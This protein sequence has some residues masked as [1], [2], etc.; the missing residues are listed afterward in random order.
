[1]RLA[2]NGFGRLG[3]SALH[4]ALKCE[5]FS[6]AFINDVASLSGGAYLFES[7]SFCGP[8]PGRGE[9]E[10]QSLIV[11]GQAIP[12][13][14]TFD[15]RTI[16]LS[17]VD[18][19]LECTGQ[20]NPIPLSRSA[21]AAGA[22]RVV[23]SGPSVGADVM[24]VIGANENACRG[25]P[26][27]SNG[28]CTTNAVASILRIVDEHFGIIAGH[29]TTVNY[30]TGSQTIVDQPKKE[31]ARSRAAAL[32]IVPSSTSAHIVSGEILSKLAGR[33]EA[34]AL[35]VP[36]ASVSSIVLTVAARE[37][38]DIANVRPTLK[39]EC[40]TSPILGWIE[41][42]LASVDLRGRFG[43]LIA[44]GLQLS[45]SAAG[46]LLRIFGLYD[47]KS[48]FANRMLDM[49]WLAGLWNEENRT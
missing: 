25:Q 34:R 17:N 44:S 48:A 23:I 12:F 14:N 5:D 28:S 49:V 9:T 42:S 45:M 15:I 13:H 7:E 21:L 8:W 30:Y 16:D 29:M 24:L 4:P 46:G 41:K 19:L 36:T 2:I 3:R 40:E 33:I 37:P 22:R 18:L 6:I 39:H 43:S 26:I 27:V 10:Q 35:R 11:D 31:H 1:M 38:T 47:N 20:A 32:S